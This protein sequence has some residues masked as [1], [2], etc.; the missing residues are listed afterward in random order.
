MGSCCS[1]GHSADDTWEQQFFHAVQWADNLEGSFL[2]NGLIEVEVP[3]GDAVCLPTD[4]AIDEVAKACYIVHDP[5]RPGQGKLTDVT[6]T[7]RR[8]LKENAANGIVKVDRDAVVALQGSLQGLTKML[9]ASFRQFNLAA[10]TARVNKHSLRIVYRPSCKPV[11]VQVKEDATF[12]LSLGA[13]EGV[14]SV[15]YGSAKLEK[16]I[17]VRSRVLTT[18]LLGQPVLVRSDILDADPCPGE[19]KVLKVTYMPRY[20]IQKLAMIRDKMSVMEDVAPWVFHEVRDL[21]SV[22]Q[23]TYFNS[24]MSL[25]SKTWGPNAWI[26]RDS[27][28][29]AWKAS[30]QQMA[31]LIGM[32]PAYLDYLKHNPQTLLPRYVGAYRV[33]ALGS[34]TRVCEVV[35]M[36]VMA[37]ARHIKAVYSLKGAPILANSSEMAAKHREEHKN[38]NNNKN[39]KSESFSF[40]GEDF[41]Q[42]V[43]LHLDDNEQS[44]TVQIVMD[45]LRRDTEFL[46]QRHMSG[47]SLAVGFAKWVATKPPVATVGQ[48]HSATREQS[49]SNMGSAKMH[50]NASFEPEIEKHVSFTGS[51]N[52]TNHATF[53]DDCKPTESN[54][55]GTGFGQSCVTGAFRGVKTKQGGAKYSV[56]DSIH[57]EMSITNLKG[58]RSSNDFTESPGMGASK[59]F[60]NAKSMGVGNFR[61]MTTFFKKDKG[62]KYPL[63][64]SQIQP[65]KA[66]DY[67]KVGMGLYGVKAQGVVNGG[68][69]ICQVFVGIDHA[70][71]EYGLR[72]P[73]ASQEKKKGAAEYAE[74]L[75]PGPFQ[76]RFCSYFDL[77]IRGISEIVALNPMADPD[78]VFHLPLPGLGRSGG[79]AAFFEVKYK[80]GK[81][82]DEGKDSD[83]YWVGKDL[84]RSRDEVIFYEQALKQIDRD[85]KAWDILKW[86]LDYGGICRAPAIKTKDGKPEE[87]DVLL[88]RNARDSFTCCRLLDIKVGVKTAVAG[89]QGKSAWAA[90]RQAC[91]DSHTTSAAQ[92]FRLEGFD[93]PPYTLR[94]FEALIEQ[95]N[96]L[97][98]AASVKQLLRFNLQRMTAVEFLPFFLDLHGLPL[99]DTSYPPTTHLSRAEHQELVLLSCIEELAGFVAACRQVPVPQQWI[100]SS[101]MMCFDS[102]SRPTRKSVKEA[103]ETPF[104]IGGARKIARVNIFDWGK[105]VLN[106]EH[107]HSNLLTDEKCQRTKYWGYYCGGIAKLLYDCCFLYVSRFWHKPRSIVFALWDKDRY[108]EN[109]FIGYVAMPFQATTQSKSVVKKLSGEVVKSGIISSAETTLQVS[110]TKAPWSPDASRLKN[111]WIA[112]VECASHVPRMDY[113][114]GTD[115]FVEVVTLPDD[116]KSIAEMLKEKPGTVSFLVTEGSHCTT[117]VIDGKNPKWSDEF[118]LATLKT[119]YQRDLLSALTTAIGREDRPVDGLDIEIMFPRFCAQVMNTKRAQL[120]TDFAQR[121]FPKI[122]VD[123]SS[124]VPVYTDKMPIEDLLKLIHFGEFLL[125]EKLT[126]KV[127]FVLVLILMAENGGA[128]MNQQMA[129]SF[130]RIFLQACPDEAWVVELQEA[131][132]PLVPCTIN[133]PSIEHGISGNHNSNSDLAQAVQLLRGISTHELREPWSAYNFQ[134]RSQDYFARGT[135]SKTPKT[136]E[137]MRNIDNVTQTR[138]RATMFMGNCMMAIDEEHEEKTHRS[139]QISSL[140]QAPHQ[141][142]KKSEPKTW[143]SSAT[144]PS[145]RLALALPIM[146]EAVMKLD[147]LDAKLK[148]AVNDRHNLGEPACLARKSDS[149]RC[150]FTV[151][152]QGCKYATSPGTHQLEFEAIGAALLGDLRRKTGGLTD[153]ELL[154]EFCEGSSNVTKLSTNS[155]SGQ[156]FFVSAGGRC[157]VKTISETEA[158][159]FGDLIPSYTEHIRRHGNSLLVRYLFLLRMDLG[160]GVGETYIT[161][162]RSVFDTRLPILHMYDLKGSTL[163]RTAKPGEGV[164]KD[165]DWVNDGQRLNLSANDATKLLEAHRHDCEYL[166]KKTFM[167]FSVLVGIAAKHTGEAPGETSPGQ[168]Y[169]SVS[170]DKPEAYFLGIIDFLVEYGLK[171]N[172]EANAYKVLGKTGASCVEPAKYASRQIEFFQQKVVSQEFEPRL[173]S[174]DSSVGSRPQAHSGSSGMSASSTDQ[175]RRDEERNELPSEPIEQSPPGSMAATPLAGTFDMADLHPVKEEEGEEAEATAR[176]SSE[177]VPAKS[178]EPVE[179]GKPHII[180]ISG[181]QHRPKKGDEPKVKNPGGARF[182]NS[183]AGHEESPSPRPPG[184]SSQISSVVSGAKKSGPLK[185]RKQSGSK[186]KK[187]GAAPS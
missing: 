68:T 27:K 41:F 45:I 28:F 172:L 174:T 47:Y 152:A 52:M 116:E 15:E 8:L 29:I 167:D 176:R 181:K 80:P 93:N 105:S 129:T 77:K 21:C 49:S 123:P 157:I 69:Q 162:M 114:S 119:E 160:P 62:G 154:E 87:V 24:I 14:V 135:T 90:F 13:V 42:S 73:R 88:I 39:K 180:I 36:N 103:A 74:D 115:S 182:S 64:S 184:T 85:E 1:P 124:D 82:Y 164:R 166:E 142:E 46:E 99:G 10:T 150:R 130:F 50:G 71:M 132:V 92:G 161:I 23:G 170:Q 26:T 169:V 158:K 185:R 20:P 138:R 7:V 16:W 122:Q 6:E 121:C 31:S 108:S 127:M 104:A 112:R 9:S 84:A 32:M 159:A 173:L 126:T 183:V 128:Y 168:S 86:T 97:K 111:G 43:T 76:R 17:D 151:P 186:D 187:D 78:K 44:S 153:E 37:S 145:E 40:L 81:A 55:S 98:V 83:N 61:K 48:N 109:D 134:N 18:I 51:G 89:W 163:G 148:T 177:A 70:L 175:E 118:E 140:F 33:H 146:I 107:M 137:E 125:E 75:P 67:T 58:P 131:F 12:H 65:P 38:Q 35:T 139:S 155:K 101:V 94:T 79:T 178:P 95:G 102:E 106:F 25:G 4:G 72:E 66:V 54:A 149:H 19:P 30:E 147:Q 133:G 179:K 110:L 136:A 34:S 2:K 113:T 3:D 100:G 117:L 57:P 144:N 53:R 56:G 96:S 60:F 171:K 156:I 63:N 141:D 11:V 165:E 91:V 59:S 120:Q 22:D 143:W 5:E